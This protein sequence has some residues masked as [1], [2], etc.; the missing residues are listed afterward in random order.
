MFLINI[1]KNI[2]L[3]VLPTKGIRLCGEGIRIC[4]INLIP[5]TRFELVI[6]RV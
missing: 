5:T 1:P 6:N 4:L 3:S 2:D